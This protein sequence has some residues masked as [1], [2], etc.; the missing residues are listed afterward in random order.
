VQGDISPI[1]YYSYCHRLPFY[2][3][4]TPAAALQCSLLDMGL[5]VKSITKSLPK[6]SVYITV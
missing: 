6:S 3:L 4:F 5:I 2:S 1:R